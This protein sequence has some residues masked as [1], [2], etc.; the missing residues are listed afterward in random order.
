MIKGVCFDEVGLFDESFPRFIDLELFIRLSKRYEFYHIREPLCRYYYTEGISTDI[1]AL[2]TAR[3]LLLK[4]YFNDIKDKDA[5]LLN[6]FAILNNDQRNERAYISAL[7]R[8]ITEMQRSIVWR[9]V[10]WLHVHLICSLL[11]LGTG[12]RRNYELYLEKARTMLNGK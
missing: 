9:A 7:H 4:K 3:V 2:C 6:Q 1:N 8:D 12:R 11:P 5:F 10:M